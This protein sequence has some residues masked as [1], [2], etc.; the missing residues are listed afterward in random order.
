MTC[1]I[2]S[3]D[4]NRVGRIAKMERGALFYTRQNTLGYPAECPRDAKVSLDFISTP[5]HRV[6][7]KGLGLLI[8][9]VPDESDDYSCDVCHRSA[10]GDGFF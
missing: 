4:L 6:F 9:Q 8:G 2:S 10:L 5:W 7:L 3:F 1:F